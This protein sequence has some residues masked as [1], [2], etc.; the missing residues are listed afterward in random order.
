M[1]IIKEGHPPSEDLYRGECH[2]C[3]AIVEWQRKEGSSSHDRNETL[4]HI[5]CPTK[6]C[7]TQIFGTKL[8]KPEPRGISER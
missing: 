8:P 4:F 7:N 6:D 3:G 2:T 1:R 5:D